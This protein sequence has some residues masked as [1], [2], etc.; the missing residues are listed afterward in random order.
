MTQ[1]NGTINVEELASETYAELGDSLQWQ[2]LDESEQENWAIINAIVA[3]AVLSKVAELLKQHGVE[4][5][6]A[7][8]TLEDE[9]A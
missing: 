5:T 4:T 2:D 6:I 1:Y 7:E 8:R 3:R 9:P